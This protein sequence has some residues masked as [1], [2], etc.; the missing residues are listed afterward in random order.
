[1]NANMKDFNEW[2][3][4]ILKHLY[5]VFPVEDDFDASDMTG[6]KEMEKNELFNGTMQF[7]K[8]E[9]FIRFNDLG[10]FGSYGYMNIVLT[11]KGLSV[12]NY[13]PDSLEKKEPLIDKL[14]G[15]LKSGSSTA[16]TAVVQGIVQAQMPKPG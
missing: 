14:K 12:L 9:E 6:E 3:A 10:T 13:S 4:K 15:A 11:A 16:I 7:L 1:M 5:S 8:N 2:V